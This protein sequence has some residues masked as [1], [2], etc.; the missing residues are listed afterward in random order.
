[1]RVARR[2]T[3]VSDGVMAP[4]FCQGTNPLHGSRRKVG[5]GC[6]R[7]R[8]RACAPGAR[9]RAALQAQ[10]ELGALPR[11]LSSRGAP[12]RAD[13]LLGGER[14]VQRHPAYAGLARGLGDRE[15]QADAE[16]LAQQLA[17]TGRE[18]PGDPVTA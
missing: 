17:R 12:S 2:R 1:M 15:L 8:R 11:S 7:G 3:H 13:R 18:T 6:G 14:A 9:G 5:P 4:L 16:V 10:P